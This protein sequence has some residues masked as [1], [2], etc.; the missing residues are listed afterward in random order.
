M[1]LITSLIASLTAALIVVSLAFCVALIRG[2]RYDIIDVA[3]GL[4]FVA[5]AWTNAVINQ[6]NS[7]GILV[8]C[9]VTLW[10]MRLS[11]H[12]F[13]RWLSST[14]EDRRYVELRQKWPARYRGLQMFTR[15]YIGQALLACVVA[16]P[17]ITLIQSHQSFGVFVIIGA[18]IWLTGLVI[19]TTAD[20]QLRHFIASAKPGGLMKEGL[21]SYSRHPNYFGEILVWWGIAIMGVGTQYALIGFIGAIVITSLII[22]VSGIPPSERGMKT[23]QGWDDYKKHTSVLI[24]LPRR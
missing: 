5:I 8:A 20:R 14:H 13:R 2:R 7:V 12:I 10:A 24:P 6:A 22:F 17:V 9:M 1:V 15:V 16:L 21:W 23:R 19:E 4:L 3:W 18:V 11:F